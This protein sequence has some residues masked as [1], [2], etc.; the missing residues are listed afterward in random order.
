MTGYIILTIIAVFAAY[1]VFYLYT[2]PEFGR[3]ATKTQK[4]AYEQTGLYK[5]GQFQ[6]LIPTE[7]KMDVMGLVKEYSNKSK[8]ATPKEPVP[9]EKL[10]SAKIAV[11]P[12]S[13]TTLTWF[14]HSAFLLQMDGK[15]ILLDPMLGDT[16]S[17]HPLIG[18]KRYN[19]NL[20]LEV[21][22]LPQIDAVIYS[23][24]HYDHLD[25]GTVN[26]IKDK[27]KTFIVPLGLGN[28][29]REW[30]VKDS[31]IQ[32]LKWWD[33]TKLGD[34]KLTCTP[35]RH[36]SGRGLTDRNTTLW[37]SWV[38]D[39][40]KDK[41]Y[42]S[43]DSGYGPHF[44]EIGEKFGP[45]DLTLMEC[46]QYNPQWEAIHMMPE[47]TAQAAKDVKAERLWP[48]HWGAFTLALHDWRDPIQ[49]VEKKAAELEIPM[50]TP[51]I[52]EQVIVG[53][54]YPQE[55]WWEQSLDKPLATK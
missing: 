29:L 38:I 23:H 12:D 5:D 21:D 16:P 7:M 32:E 14:G 22:K 45:F 17:P 2:S 26:K 39:G 9:F 44:K 43:G 48:I 42:F 41:I 27:V 18:S 30:G 36:F 55:R 40:Q 53:E 52:G 31:Q 33:E 15:N 46:G 4:L 35:S 49:R 1:V 34:I 37:S 28:H 6:N 54:S 51:R 20:P 24:D 8:F 3:S 47:Q 11:A 13:L 25:Y 10:D 50:T 19:K